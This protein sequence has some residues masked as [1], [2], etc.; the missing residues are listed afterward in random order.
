MRGLI[1]CLVHMRRQVNKKKVLHRRDEKEGVG[2]K[3]VESGVWESMG[4]RVSDG[5]FAKVEKVS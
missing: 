3:R 1:Y 4:A 5:T 2:G